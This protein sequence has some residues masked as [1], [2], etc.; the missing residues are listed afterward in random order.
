MAS[1]SRTT[2]KF[3]TNRLSL[4]TNRTYESSAK[5]Y[6]QLWEWNPEVIKEI[7][8]Y[9]IEPFLKFCRRSG[10]VLIVGCGTGRDYKLLSQKGYDCMGI[11]YSNAMVT[12]ARK[13]NVGG[14]FKVQDAKT[15][16]LKGKFDGIYC[17]S[18][19][20]HVSKTDM[21]SI[22][23]NFKNA[24]NKDGVIYI[25]LKLGRPGIYRS[26]DLNRDRYY[27]VYK[28]IEVY[29]TLARLG[30]KVKSHFISEHTDIVRPKWLSLIL[31]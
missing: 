7:K 12:L 3:F 31:N 14:K 20:T 27:Q 24:L 22:L 18:A 17:E 13:N 28:K 8:K 2:Y 23:R 26:T 11:D 15:L 6:E 10:R 16:K 9:N 30:L 5:E 4:L 25:A 1:F 29:K 19:L 21:V